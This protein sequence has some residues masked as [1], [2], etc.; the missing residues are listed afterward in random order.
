MFGQIDTTF[1]VDIDTAGKKTCFRLAGHNIEPVDCA[2]AEAWIEPLHALR[3]LPCVTLTAEQA[4]VV[5][6]GGTIPTAATVPG[7]GPIALA[8]DGRLL[9]IG[10]PRGNRIQ[11]RTVLA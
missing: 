3:H 6:H 10:E 4:R 11:P 7:S 8:A 5:T 2:V 9:A 1:R